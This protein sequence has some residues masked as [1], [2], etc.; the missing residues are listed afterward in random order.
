MSSADNINILVFAIILGL[1]IGFGFLLGWVTGRG[2]LRRQLKREAKDKPITNRQYNYLIKL[3]EDAGL[4]PP[5]RALTIDQ[6]S[7]MIDRL[8]RELG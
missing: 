1:P 8:T 2:Q 3:C 7:D 6:A 4:D 5:S